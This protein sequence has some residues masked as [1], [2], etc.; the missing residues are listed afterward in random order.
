MADQDLNI[1]IQTKTKGVNE[2]KQLTRDINDVKGKIKELDD[3]GKR[4]SA[5]WDIYTKKIREL[6]EQKERL[7]KV[8]GDGVQRLQ[9]TAKNLTIIGMGVRNT[10]E[11]FK[12]LSTTLNDTNKNFGDVSVVAM[13]LGADLVGVVAGVDALAKAFPRL[14]DGIKSVGLA[15]GPVLIALAAMYV[16]FTKFDE[17]L[18]ALGRAFRFLSGEISFEEG[19]AEFENL[20][21]EI[22][23]TEAD[24]K[25]ATQALQDFIFF[26]EYMSGLEYK[27]AQ[28]KNEIYGK[29]YDLE[30]TGFKD[31]QEYK[32]WLYKMDEADIKQSD[33]LRDSEEK[34]RQE[35]TKTIQ[36]KKTQ[37]KSSLQQYKE[38]DIIAD[39]IK[40]KKEELQYIELKEGLSVE[41]LNSVL[42]ELGTLDL[43]NASLS[44]KIA[45]IE[46]EQQLREKILEI[47]KTQGETEDKSTKAIGYNPTSRKPTVLSVES[48][49]GG[50]MDAAK[51][52]E[53]VEEQEVKFEDIFSNVQNIANI[54]GLGADT[55]VGKLLSGLQ[56]AIS[57][58]QSVASIISSILNIASGGF[59]SFLGFATGGI[60]GGEGTGT[61]D[62][63]LI[64][65][66][67]GEA[68]VP[69]YRVSELGTGF[70]NWVM[71]KNN[72]TSNGYYANGGMVTSGISGQPIS[73]ILS[74]EMSEMQSVKVVT[75]GLNKANVRIGKRTIR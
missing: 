13:K 34:Y 42:T 52:S 36:V 44:Q 65:V 48:V 35:L 17:Q 71:G 53:T 8:F 38:I 33:K 55:F 29:T 50:K 59:L 26:T 74:G 30:G 7:N 46:Y 24:L 11:D 63:N 61:S 19:V 73:I 51:S 28:R 2:W 22:R 14:V 15:I 1:N 62:S 57:L 10:V 69:A 3:A 18:P 6:R 20:N 41:I 27:L 70:M 37:S 23:Q 45:L 58:A 31:Q 66:S 67:R 9:N 56:S 47:T 72:G 40:K 32:E 39:L 16:F 64:A 68:V 4:G 75:R 21:S 12:E 43:T 49:H 60:V 54:L 25:S 5:E